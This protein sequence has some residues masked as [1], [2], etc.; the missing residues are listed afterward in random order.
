MGTHRHGKGHLPSCPPLEAEKMRGS[1]LGLLP[2][3]IFRRSWR[4]DS[5]YLGLSLGVY[6]CFKRSKLSASRGFAPNPLTS[7]LRP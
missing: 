4:T 2:G 3:L 6:K 7:G 5:K 1:R